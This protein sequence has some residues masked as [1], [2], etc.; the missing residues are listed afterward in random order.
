LPVAWFSYSGQ[1]T[2]KA[3]RRLVQG[4]L[5]KFELA[6]GGVEPEGQKGQ[7]QE[8]TTLH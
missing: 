7:S 5:T 3:R 1:G 4:H 6:F 2:T 8:Q